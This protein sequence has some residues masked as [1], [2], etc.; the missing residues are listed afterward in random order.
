MAERRS[1]LRLEEGLPLFVDGRAGVVRKGLEALGKQ[2]RND[3]ILTAAVGA[4]IL[5]GH[6]P[7]IPLPASRE[8]G[9]ANI[10]DLAETYEAMHRVAAIHTTGAQCEAGITCCSARRASLGSCSRSA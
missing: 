5:I 9:D 4:S 7:D 3:S 1:G 8:D 10:L 2:P 6:A